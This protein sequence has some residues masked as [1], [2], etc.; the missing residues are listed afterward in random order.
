[1]IA[2][3][4]LAAVER[5]T[6]KLKSLRKELCKML[7]ACKAGWVS[8]CRVLESLGLPPAGV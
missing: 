1:M 7:E 5:R 3:R 4:H 8:N 2:S 6:A